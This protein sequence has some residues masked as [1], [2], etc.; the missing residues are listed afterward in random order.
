M[1]H[2]LLVQIVSKTEMKLELTA[3]VLLAV[4]VQSF[5]PMEF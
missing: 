2:V 5:V 3:E 4:H 1:V